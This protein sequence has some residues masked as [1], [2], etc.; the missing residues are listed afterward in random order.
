M[1]KMIQK[2]LPIEISNDDAVSIQQK[3]QTRFNSLFHRIRLEYLSRLGLDESDYALTCL[4]PESEL[5][6]G[7]LYMPEPGIICYIKALRGQGYLEAGIIGNDKLENTDALFAS[8]RESISEV[9]PNLPAWQLPEE[10]EPLQIEGADQ[11]NVNIDAKEMA[12]ARSLMDSSARSLLAKI[13]DAGSIFLNKIY[14]E[15]RKTAED[16]IRKFED[17]K[18][19][20]KEYAVLCRR[21]G[22]QI[23][24]V[25]D[26]STIDESSQKSFKC[27]ICGNPIAQ[28]VVEEIATSNALCTEMFNENKWLLILIQGILGEMG[29]DS[30]DIKVYRAPKLPTRLFLS[31]NGQRYLLVLCTEPLN[32]D[33]ANFISAHVAAYKLHQAIIISTSN[34]SMLMR[35][36]LAKINDN[37]IFHFICDL[38]NLDGDI[39]E[40]LTEQLRGC[41]VKQLDDISKATPVSIPNLVL[42]RMMP[43]PVQAQ[44]QN[45]APKP[46][47]AIEALEAK[48]EQPLAEDVPEEPAPAPAPD[49]MAESFSAHIPE[50]IPEPVSVSDPIAKFI[51]EPAD[52]N[53]IPTA[54]ADE[55]FIPAIPSEAIEEDI[56]APTDDATADDDLSESADERGKSSK[57]HKKG[58]K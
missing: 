2:R 43:R 50:P 31:L 1:L 45:E 26:R 54:A 22:Q 5:L 28:E 13:K 40:I 4:P 51:P 11:G 42:A 52:E 16:C 15:D 18:L 39:R 33:Q 36:H 37:T 23:L 29:V 10:Y 30:Q 24:R 25:A 19:I 35:H 17:L 12:A 58:K 41:V 48:P 38:N 14:T 3:L 44:P 47:E 21:T 32:L 55:A 53:V 8:L 34:I 49:F 20:N 57:K 6:L 7:E 56:L 9:R 46:I 27:F